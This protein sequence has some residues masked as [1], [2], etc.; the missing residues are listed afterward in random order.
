MS[1]IIYSDQNSDTI[2]SLESLRTKY[3]PLIPNH[4]YDSSLDVYGLELFIRQ[5]D[6]TNQKGLSVNNLS[7]LFDK[8]FF[9]SIDIKDSYLI[10]KNDSIQ[11]KIYINNSYIKDIKK[12][13][14]GANFK[15]ENLNAIVD[16]FVI[17]N[18][19]SSINLDQEKFSLKNI[20]LNNQENFLEGDMVINFDKDFKIKNI[21]NSSLDFNFNPN[22]FEPFKKNVELNGN[23]S[24][25]IQFSGT[26]EDLKVN[27][28]FLSHEL[29][30]LNSE[31]NIKNILSDDFEID[32][33]IKN[34]DINEAYLKSNYKF[35]KRF[36]LPLFQ[37]SL[38]IKNKNLTFIFNEL[39]ESEKNEIKLEGNIMLDSKLSYQLKIDSSFTENDK[40]L[41]IL[42]LNYLNL[43]TS[44][45]GSNKLTSINSDINLVKD[46]NEF[47]F[48][49][50]SK[51]VNDNF[52]GQI[53]LF[54]KNVKIESN[55]SGN[56]LN[57]L[58]VIDSKIN[59]N[60]NNNSEDFEINT[61]SRLDL[62]LSD[63][64][65][66]ISLLKLEKLFYKSSENEFSFENLCEINNILKTNII[67]NGSNYDFRIFLK[68][69]LL[70]FNSFL[71]ENLKI[72]GYYKNSN[73][74]NLDIQ[75][76]DLIVNN[77]YEINKNPISGIINSVINVNRSPENR[78]FLMN[79]N[80]SNLQIK[81][82][83]LGNMNINIFG[84]TDYRSYAVNLDLVK[85]DSTIL[86][87]EGSIIATNDKPNIDID[88][89]INNLDIS[90]IEK[91]GSNTMSNISSNISGKINLW[92]QSDNIQHNG[93]LFL[94]DSKFTIPYLNIDY[95]LSNNSEVELYNQN[96]EF[97]N[98]N[99]DTESNSSPTLLV[100]KINH[101]DYKN[102][103][104]DLNFQSDRLYILNKEYNENDSFYGEAYLGGDIKIYGPTNQVSINI[105][106]ET[107][108]G[109]NITI[110]QTNNYSFD[111]FSFITF[112]N[113]N[114]NSKEITNSNYIS[115][116]SDK[117]LD[118]NINLEINDN[119]E[120]EIT[121]DQETGSY[122]SGKGN[123]DLFM[124]IDSDGK[125]NIFGDFIATEGIYNFR[126]LA[127]IDKKFKLKKGGTIVWDG[128][129]LLAQMNIQASYEVPGGANPA[130]LLDNPNFN[131]KIPT[132]VE[133][134]LTGELTKPDSPEFEIFFPNTS[135]TVISEINYKLNDPEIRQLQAISLLTQGIF[136]NE[137]S[138]SI[139][140]VTNNI[141]EKV[142]EVFSDILEAKTLSKQ[143]GEPPL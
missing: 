97:N 123:G 46:E 126:N 58:F 105:N 17:N 119:A 78:T 6:K 10:F 22:L 96:F 125:F 16:N 51:I 43:K 100:G 101:Q 87:G 29:F 114:S 128:D 25:E 91:I 48:I 118:L 112:S 85:Q 20:Y 88:F 14:D 18:F 45:S 28:L 99:L 124:E 107:Q 23:I 53:E 90:F 39:N 56:M 2:F 21:S 35:N 49:T 67:S 131:K 103:N 80:F 136:I 69:G 79:S 98:I 8:I 50:N 38:N 42:D 106:G 40:L 122:I 76:S 68:D 139:E 132:D 64:K 47:K 63:S 102:W 3:I 7:E 129:P 4:Q 12:V 86:K 115:S 104:L 44:I 140:G 71:G 109:T 143:V 83:D 1:D 66:I 31:I 117:S 92:G 82:Y 32:T 65:N 24:G 30:E 141:Y 70:Q 116:Q 95:L 34:L 13:G 59:V 60:G 94:N 75:I 84:N 61:N 113:L 36:N 93:K 77:F 41:E 52:N 54:S 111:D 120:V 137:V 89:V 57:K 9:D 33:F 138:V 133:I 5:N 27:K 81:N 108:S 127:L 130:L 11:N 15:V 135:S 37:G 72:N 134:K 19:N 55:V 74:L 62:D 26:E 121:V 110:P 73:N 142:S